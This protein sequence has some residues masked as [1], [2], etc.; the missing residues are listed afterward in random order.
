MGDEKAAENAR[1]KL[2]EV[3]ERKLEVNPDDVIV[4]S[5]LAGRYAQLGDKEKTYRTL[6][7]VVELDPADGLALYN[8]ACTYAVMGDKKEA[9]VCLRNASNN[10]YK[11]VSMWVQSD[12]DF[13]PYHDDPEF[14]ALLEE[15]R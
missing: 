13:Y 3:A 11:F 12:P 15:I 5:R 8:C 4:L 7:R 9:F 2:L 6:K 14:K 10:G 1:R